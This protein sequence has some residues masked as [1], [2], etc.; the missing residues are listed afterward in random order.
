[1]KNRRAL[2]ACT[3]LC[4]AG[5]NGFSGESVGVKADPVRLEQAMESSG[6]WQDILEQIRLHPRAA[7]TLLDEPFDHGRRRVVVFTSHRFGF[8]GYNPQAI[9]VTD[10][11]YEP[12]HWL[13]LFHPRKAP[14][15]ARLS[16]GEEGHPVLFVL[17]MVRAEGNV[18][19]SFSLQDSEI[20]PLEEIADEQVR[21]YVRLL[22]RASS[23]IRL[24]DNDNNRGGIDKDLHREE[25]VWDRMRISYDSFE[26][27]RRTFL[28]VIS[29]LSEELLSEIARLGEQAR[30][31]PSLQRVE[32]EKRS[33]SHDDIVDFVEAH[34]DF[35]DS[36]PDAAEEHL[37][38][39]QGDLSSIWSPN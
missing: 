18:V 14:S 9:I 16:V 20:K 23:L 6:E 11:D 32:P 39:R 30:A 27:A 10:Q 4:L 37:R 5:T 15:A 29:G 31:L 2:W 22:N 13:D 35:F 1:M 36:L 25:A 28:Q 12:L 21:A 38:A 3:V 19:R 26:S 24:I 17:N 8:P 7:P 34:R 33:P